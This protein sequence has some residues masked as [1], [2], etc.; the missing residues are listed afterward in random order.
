MA[1]RV[2]DD[3]NPTARRQ[4]GPHTKNAMNHTAEIHHPNQE[5]NAVRNV[6]T[7]FRGR[8]RRVAMFAAAVLLANSGWASDD[9]PNRPIRMVVPASAGSSADSAARA[10]SQR[11]SEILGKPIAVDNKVGAGG[12][13]GAAEVA[14]TTAD[15]YTLL[16]G[17]SITQALYPAIGQNVNYDPIK[18]FVSLGQTF[19][20]A[21]V[22]VCN[23]QVPF[24]DF[25][26][27]VAHAKANPGKLTFAN[28]GVGGGNHFSNELL[29]TMA[30]IKLHHV[31]FRGNAPGIQAVLGNVVDCTSQ[32]E[33]KP[34]VDA[35]QLKAFATTGKERDPRFPDLPTVEEAGVRGYVTTWWHAVF[36]PAGTPA[37]V[38]RKL[39][40]AV[41]T[42]ALDPGVYSKIASIGLVPAY[43]PPE[44]VMQ[45]TQVDMDTFKRIAKESAIQLD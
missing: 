38:R 21:T 17:T 41:K 28:S 2:L 32:T 24:K 8:V 39:E 40:S 42:A 27:M 25:K 9:Y 4:R 36:A 23:A 15:G 14:R 6:L 7:P 44:Q 34:Y 37:A 18:D 26:G 10:F 31:P 13:I 11:L 30:D 22:I 33:V 20:F 19:W 1:V 43:L 35:G 16:Y 3:N 5:M 45:R 12:R 29:A